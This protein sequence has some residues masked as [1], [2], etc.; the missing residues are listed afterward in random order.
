MN[1]ADNVQDVHAFLIKDHADK[2]HHKT[3]TKIFLC[4]GDE[5]IVLRNSHKV[6][7][8]NQGQLGQQGHAEKRS[9]VHFEAITP[10]P[11]F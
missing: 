3:K 1:R 10:Q 9:F 6:S 5:Y 8:L 2:P 4:L 11:L 7:A